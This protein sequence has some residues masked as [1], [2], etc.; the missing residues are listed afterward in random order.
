MLKVTIGVALLLLIALVGYRQTFTR[1]RL[2]AG[3][4]LIFLTGTEFIFVGVALGDGLIGLLDESTIRSLTPLFS[5]GLGAVGLI[6]GIQLDLRMIGRFPSR[7]L[8]MAAIQAITTMAVV[9]TTFAFLLVGYFGADPESAWLAA[10][11]LAATA[12][13]TAQTSLAL[14]DREFQLRGT[15]LMGLLRYISSLDAAAGLLLLGVAFAFDNTH[16][17]FGFDAANGLQ[18]LFLSLCLGTLMGFLLKVLTETRCSEEELLIFVVGTVL[19]SSGVALFLE[20]SPLFVNAITGLLIAN[21]NG[22]KDRIFTLLARLEK[23]VYL[24][25]LVLAGAVW[26]ADPAWAFPLGAVYLLLRFA[27]KMGGGFL[28]AR[29]APPEVP[30]PSGLGLGLIA[31]GGMA[32][33][34]VMNYYQLSDAPI[35]DAVVTIV[36]VGVIASELVAPSLAVRL[37][38]R[39][40]EIER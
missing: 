17:V 11:V 6:F 25:F 39:S 14:I 20:L 38:R 19:L 27:G 22:A 30:A 3:A 1:L 7:Y 2:P 33:A 8:V 4:R 40:G 21:L 5:L 9:F 24:V 32:I 16:S 31:Q 10:S 36:L 34:M 23:P 26:H 29:V 37:L 28:A 12:A 13:C 35:T 18:W 15:G